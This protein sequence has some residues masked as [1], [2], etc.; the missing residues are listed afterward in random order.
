MST[1]NNP[2]TSLVPRQQ[3]PFGKDVL[4][5]LLENESQI[6][7]RVVRDFV[8]R[9][10]AWL[11]GLAN[12]DVQV[13][14][15]GLRQMLRFEIAGAFYGY[16]PS[17]V[18]YTLDKLNRLFFMVMGN[19]YIRTTHQELEEE[20]PSLN[21][22]L[23]LELLSGLSA[24]LGFYVLV[25]HFQTDAHSQ[26]KAWLDRA[27]DLFGQFRD[28]ETWRP[29]RDTIEQSA[30]IRQLLGVAIADDEPYYNTTTPGY[31]RD[32]SP[33]YRPPQISYQS[34][35]ARSH[36]YEIPSLEKQWR[37]EMSGMHFQGYQQCYQETNALFD[38]TGMII[39]AERKR[40]VDFLKSLRQTLDILNDDPLLVAGQW[41]EMPVYPEPPQPPKNNGNQSEHTDEIFEKIKD[42]S[43]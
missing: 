2:A 12:E 27:C 11:Y 31:I 29:Q 4:K 33:V 6:T 42:V 32:P 21:T 17:D 10:V 37:A 34:P 35:Y 30:T 36:T 24:P 40:L 8:R 16:D 13:F 23:S 9:Y 15:A 1:P 26:D 43:Q 22:H 5:F 25:R 14:S 7:N 41:Q 3:V 18:S 39:E 38:H 20:L 28:L 19:A